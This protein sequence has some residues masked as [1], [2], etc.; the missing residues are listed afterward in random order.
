LREAC[1][2]GADSA[3]EGITEP[4]AIVFRCESHIDPDLSAE[5]FVLQPGLTSAED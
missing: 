3:V 1:G 4:Q 5:T 2:I